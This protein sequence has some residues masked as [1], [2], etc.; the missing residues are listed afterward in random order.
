MLFNGGGGEEVVVQ[1]HEDSRHISKG[2]VHQLLERLRGVLRLKRHEE[3][4]KQAE[5]GDCTDE[6]E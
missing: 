1:V 3:V 6:N 2:A 5:G 4:L